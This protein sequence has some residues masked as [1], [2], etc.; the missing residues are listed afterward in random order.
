MLYDANRSRIL[1]QDGSSEFSVE[2]YCER[3]LKN[4]LTEK[5]YCVETLDTSLYE[6]Y[7]RH[8]ITVRETLELDVNDRTY[9]D[10]D[11]EFVKKRIY[12]SSRFQ[13]TDQEHQRI[14][15]EF[16]FFEETNNILQLKKLIHLIESFKEKNIIW[17]VGRGSS[18]ASYIM[19]LLEVHDVDPLKHDIPFEELSKEGE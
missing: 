13:G 4:E 10:F 12:Q 8:Q 14:E 7:F 16:Q 3:L 6:K 17:G 2:A 18:C 5:D 1:H 9:S 15:R 19:Y 11:L